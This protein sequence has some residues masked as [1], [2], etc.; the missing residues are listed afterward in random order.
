MIETNAIVNMKIGLNI[1]NSLVRKITL[2][3]T[4]NCFHVFHMNYSTEDRVT[5]CRGVPASF[6]SSQN[7]CY[8]SKASEQA[9]I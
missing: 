2:E 9:R 7:L 4:S 6:S 3:I 5:Y 8:K 1:I